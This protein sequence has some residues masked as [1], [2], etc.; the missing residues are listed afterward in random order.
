MS[1]IY[2][3]VRRSDNEIVFSFPAGGRYQVY[4]ANGIASMRQMLDDEITA[5]P[6]TLAQLLIRLGYRIS[7][8]DSGRKSGGDSA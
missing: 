8:P 6:A 4:T 7:P 3:L 1:D 5:T 2:D